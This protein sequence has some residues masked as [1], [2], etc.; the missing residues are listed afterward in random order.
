MKTPRITGKRYRIIIL[1]ALAGLIAA[2]LPISASGEPLSENERQTVASFNT[3]FRRAIEQ[4]RPAV[5]NIQ[6]RRSERPEAIFRDRGEGS[7]CIIDPQ[8][9]II[10]NNHVV[11][12]ME[13]IEVVLSDQRRF[14]AEEVFLDPDTDL[15]VIRIDPQ[16]EELPFASFGDS[17]KT[18]VGDF[19]M[20]MG[21][22][23][24]LTQTVTMGIIS[25]KGRETHILDKWG[26][27][28]FIQ[29]DADINR[30][31]SGG[32]LV[33]LYG[34]IIGINSNIFSPTGTSAGYGFAIP[35]KMAQ[36]VAQQL[37]DDKEVKRG[38]MGVSMRG[39][40]EIREI[41]ERAEK[42]NIPDSFLKQFS[43]AR[44]LL[45][46]LPDEI[47]GVLIIE[48]FDKTPAKEAGLEALD[49]VTS[50]DDQDVVKG[51]D[52]RNYIA[53]H[54]PGDRVNCTIWRNSEVLEIQMT[55]GDRDVA[56]KKE[57]AENEEFYAQ[58]NPHRN[59]P[60]GHPM[61]PEKKP[62]YGKVKLG[63]RAVELIPKIA[64]DSGYDVETKGIM[65]D[66]VAPGSLAQE[67]GLAPGD[68]IVSIDDVAVDSVDQL[69]EM[70]TEA[71]L[72]ETGITMKIRNLQGERVHVIKQGAD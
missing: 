67:S 3:V 16:G 44:E 42:D 31:N 64:R 4:V 60:F 10:T 61:I 11:E 2:A 27:E 30:G 50:V 18:L 22:P 8:G 58:R 38:W 66:Y 19:V 13:H 37:I 1:S 56:K 43:S 69:R 70:I 48:V 21:S 33:N 15:A 7:G 36:K 47:N 20:A 40:D 71:D 35:S 28:D 49:I 46:K 68:I 6:V 63:V 26:F 39:V 23:F 65:I 14:E 52:L 72:A 34:E 55:L 29:T 24:G 41:I 12:E 5:V 32:P 25:Y 57:E 51:N 53:G 17:D 62:E 54:K 9:Y 59:L 45:E